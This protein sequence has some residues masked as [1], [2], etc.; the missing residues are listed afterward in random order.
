MGVKAYTKAKEIEEKRIEI[1]KTKS[2]I[3]FYE[4]QLK[5][6]ENYIITVKECLEKQKEKLEKLEKESDGI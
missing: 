5:R 6:C 1:D 4:K 2:N 3:K